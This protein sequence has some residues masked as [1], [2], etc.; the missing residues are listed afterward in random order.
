MGDTDSLETKQGKRTFANMAFC[1]ESIELP[2]DYQVSEKDILC[3]RGRSCYNHIGNKRFRIT[4]A[5]NLKRYVNAKTKVKKSQVVHSIVQHL[6][7]S[8][9]VGGFIKKN[10]RTGRYMLV[11]DHLAREKVGHAL[12]DALSTIKRHQR[13]D[14]SKMELNHQDNVSQAEQAIFKSLDLYPDNTTSY[15]EETG[16]MFKPD[17]NASLDPVN[18]AVYEQSSRACSPVMMSI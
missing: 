6:R 4:I 14:P 7:H 2:K 5:M 11:S 13:D 18:L 12:R 8:T 9:S 16:I 10:H 1:D 17:L 3:G 15:G